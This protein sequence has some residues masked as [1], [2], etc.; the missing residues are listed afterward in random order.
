MAV[1]QISRIQVRRGQKNSSSGV[2]Q[3]SSAE[4]AWAVDSQELFIGNGSVSDGS[5]Y[6]GNTKILTEHDN[7]LEYT[8][9]YRYASTDP[10]ISLSV[11]RSLQARL[12][13]L[14]A[15]SDFGAVGDGI[16][17]CAAAFETAF[18][19]LFRNLDSNYKKVLIIPN[20][21]YKF[22]SGFAIPSGVIIRGETPLG[23][24]LDIGSYNI[25]FITSTG[26]ENIQFDSTN[27]PINVQ[28]S[29]LT[30]KRTTGQLMLSGLADSQL[31]DVKFQGT[32]VL[33]DSVNLATDIAMVGS[34]NR[35]AGV[36]ATGITFAS[37][38]FESINIG[39][40]C[41]QTNKFDT[42]IKF[43]DC[44][45][46]IN[47]TSIYI[48]GVSEQ[49][50][51]WQVIDCKFE[52]IHNYVFK[53][54]AGIGTLIQRAT[55]KNCGNGLSL[56]YSPS[57]FIVYFGEKTN[58]IVLD[59][60]S[61]R[62]QTAG[63]VSS[64]LTPAISEVYNSDKTSFI[65]RNYVTIFKSDSFRPGAAFSAL[66]R[67]TIVNY[68]LSLDVFTRVGKL[69]L[70]VGDNLSQVSI[71]DEYQYSPQYV[72]SEGGSTMTNFE[73]GAE[74]KDNDSDSGIETIILLYKNPIAGGY[75]GSLSF[76]VSYGV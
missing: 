8:G 3:L 68:S 47:D 53:S 27:R 12:D 16:T 9:S 26:L 29:N 52:E 42:D 4:F 59:C 32:Y 48:Q 46:F 38:K 43:I 55:F 17:D 39:V 62:Q 75:N 7:I 71:T 34:I 41:L 2:P 51:N 73:F 63:I 76:D 22:N 49:G 45:F 28:I 15:V 72:V 56:P 60:I 58:N 70:T 13:E 19:Q 31:T 37:C 10:S 40:H 21:I 67:Y 25:R 44:E 1:V 65:N 11:S 57:Q 24:V 61:D 20:G 66:N 14:V 74:L 54:T 50:N 30:I 33:G 6:V 64:T 5:P 18:T 23:T 69:T 36:S 35:V